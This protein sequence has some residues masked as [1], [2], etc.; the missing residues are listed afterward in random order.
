MALKREKEKKKK[1]RI[2]FDF[3]LFETFCVCNLTKHFRK[4][5]IFQPFYLMFGF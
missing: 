3:L 2:N 5:G 4:E 1:N